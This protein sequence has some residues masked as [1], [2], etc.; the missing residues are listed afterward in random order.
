MIEL[1]TK[2]VRLVRV[3]FSGNCLMIN[4]PR[5]LMRKLEIFKG[6]YLRAMKQGNGILY[7]ALTNEEKLLF[8]GVEGL[9]KNK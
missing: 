1:Y 5:E 4:I 2:K 3:Q 8:K 7:Q 6:D 9:G